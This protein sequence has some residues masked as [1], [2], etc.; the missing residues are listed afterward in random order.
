MSEKI[1]ILYDNRAD[2]ATMTASTAAGGLGPGNLQ[3]RLLS[4]VARTTGVSAEWW[5]ADFGE[6]EAIST[7]ALWNHNLTVAASVRI[8]ISDN[9]DMSAPAFDQTLYAWPPAYGAGEIGAGMCGYGGAPILTGLNAYKPYSVFRLGA[10]HEGRYLQLDLAD[11]GNAA[12]YLQAGRLIAGAGWQPDRNFSFGWTLDWVD[13][14]AQSVM[15]GGAVWVDSRE[16]YRV[17]EA[18]FKFATKADALGAFNDL[19]RI[20]GSS[21]EILVLP[22]PDASLPDQYRTAIYGIPERGGLG[23]IKQERLNQFSVTMKLRELTA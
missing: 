16:K 2:A 21:R 6:A 8:R 3:D 18:P 5:R 15:D 22:F 23:S 17:L 10:T 4:K 1:L 20:V 14:S 19:K 11:P 9:A 13:P 12:G 7:V